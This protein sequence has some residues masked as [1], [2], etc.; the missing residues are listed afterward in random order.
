[1]IPETVRCHADVHFTPAMVARRAAA[2]LAPTGTE[3]V[4]DVGAGVGKLCSLAAK[5]APDAVFVGIERRQHLVTIARRIARELDLTNVLFL[6]GDATEVDWSLFDSFYF[7]N[8]FAEYLPKRISSIDAHIEL[9]PAHHAF[10]VA[11]VEGQLAR[12]RQGARVVT[13]HGF[14]GA[15]PPGYELAAEV[16]IATDRLELWIKCR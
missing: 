5:M 9:D 14:G 4:L 8:P 6:H 16:P 15:I 2:L 3:W 7:Y 11:H 1:M 13:Y 10:Y 12:A